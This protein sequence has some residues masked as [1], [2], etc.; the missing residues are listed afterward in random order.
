MQ[1]NTPFRLP[2]DVETTAPGQLLTVVPSMITLLL[3][4]RP[5]VIVWPPSSELSWAYMNERQS[6]Y[7][8]NEVCGYV[9]EVKT[10]RL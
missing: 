5:P 1:Q 10:G 3:P 7:V 2:V 8:D 4:V 9:P 6:M